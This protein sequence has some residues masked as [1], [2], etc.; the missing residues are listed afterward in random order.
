ML[1]CIDASRKA[2]HVN[3]NDATRQFDVILG[4]TI[5]VAWVD[6]ET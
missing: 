2:H 4:R 3:Y 6:P 1:V 5:L